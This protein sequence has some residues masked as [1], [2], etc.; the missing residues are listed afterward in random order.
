MSTRKAPRILGGSAGPDNISNLGI[1]GYLS[2]LKDFFPVMSH[3]EM[4]N[5][6]VDLIVL[7]VHF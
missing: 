2:P 1:P 3:I 5:A 4:H 6:L 7:D